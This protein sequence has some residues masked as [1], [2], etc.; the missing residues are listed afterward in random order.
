M[1]MFGNAV[2]KLV[3]VFALALPVVGLCV[4]VPM[5]DTD[6]LREKLGEAGWQV[7]KNAE[8]D[9]IVRSPVFEDEPTKTE[10][11]PET[12]TG[13]EPLI[14]ATDVDALGRRLAALGW[15][16]E[17]DETGALLIIPE[18][19]NDTTNSAATGAVTAASASEMDLSPNEDLAA[20]LSASGWRVTRD[21]N[22]DL[23]V[24]RGIEAPKS[25]QPTSVIVKPSDLAAAKETLVSAGWKLQEGSDNSMLLFP[26]REARPATNAPQTGSSEAMTSVADSGV[27]LPIDSW[28][29][30]KTIAEHW[31]DAQTNSDELLVGKIRKINWIY[32]VSIVERGA[33]HRLKNQIAIRNRDGGVVP[34]F[35]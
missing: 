8:G 9:L 26:T 12:R 2:G 19:G 5:Q 4:D 15:R 29:K 11:L 27:E 33:P 30:A 22:G 31:L 17:R 32:L 6:L 25:Q 14:P 35:R 18:N 3:A 1:S 23:N 34:V 24:S 13:S 21:A 16:V 7:E 10:A 28:G 20:L